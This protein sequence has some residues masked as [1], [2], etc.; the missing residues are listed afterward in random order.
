[1]QTNEP[2]DQYLEMLDRETEAFFSDQTIER[3]FHIEVIV[4]ANRF[5]VREKVSKRIIADFDNLSEAIKRMYDEDDCIL[6]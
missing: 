6:D 2:L 4:S 5:Y 3:G 1:M